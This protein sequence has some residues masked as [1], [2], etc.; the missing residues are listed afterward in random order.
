MI[1]SKAAAAAT[2]ANDALAG[3]AA[4]AAQKA[5]VARQAASIPAHRAEF[6]SFAGLPPSRRTLA[7]VRQS[8]TGHG[9]ALA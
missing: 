4:V 3:Q 1:S 8:D 2:A 5:S 9:H 7:Q 6:S